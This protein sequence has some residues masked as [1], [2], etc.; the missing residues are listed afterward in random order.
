MVGFRPGECEVL[1]NGGNRRDSF[2]FIEIGRDLR[3]H[4][5]NFAPGIGQPSNTEDSHGGYTDVADPPSERE[6]TAG[7]PTV[8]LR[9]LSPL[10]LGSGDETSAD[11]SQKDSTYGF[12]PNL[13]APDRLG[14]ALEVSQDIR[15]HCR[16]RYPTLRNLLDAEAG[17]IDRLLAHNMVA[18]YDSDGLPATPS[19]APGGGGFSALWN[20]SALS[21][22]WNLVQTSIRL[23]K[24]LKIGRPVPRIPSP[25]KESPFNEY[26]RNVTNDSAEFQEMTRDMIDVI[27]IKRVTQAKEKASSANTA[28]GTRSAPSTS[29]SGGSTG[30][31]DRGINPT[32]SR[33][34]A[35][36][37]GNWN[38]RSGN[39]DGGA[40]GGEERRDNYRP[41]D[42]VDQNGY[43]QLHD[44]KFD[45]SNHH[46][47]R[48]C[49]IT[50]GQI[51]SRER[52]E[53]THQVMQGLGDEAD[54]GEPQDVKERLYCRHELLGSFPQRY[55]DV[56][57][58]ESKS[59][60]DPEPPLRCEN[61]QTLKPNLVA[62][63]GPYLELVPDTQT[64]PICEQDGCSLG[65]SKISSS[66]ISHPEEKV[67]TPISSKRPSPFSSHTAFS[68]HSPNDEPQNRSFKKSLNSKK[69]RPS[70]SPTF[71]LPAGQTDVELETTVQLDAQRP[72]T[73]LVSKLG[74]NPTLVTD[75]ADDV[76]R[77]GSHD[78][79]EAKD[80]R[81]ME[82]HLATDF[83]RGVRD[84]VNRW[85]ATVPIPNHLN[86]TSTA[87]SKA[88]RVDCQITMTDHPGPIS[89]QCF[90]AASESSS[91]QYSDDN[92]KSLL[93]VNFDV[94]GTGDEIRMLYLV[95][96]EMDRLIDLRASR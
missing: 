89:E 52:A 26:V 62:H 27:R 46:L 1:E 54:A 3:T 61:S 20:F 6:Q 48:E 53:D 15:D 79:K 81:E 86:S 42:G 95:K 17:D 78:I 70:E 85:L 33:R 77:T 59:T 39:D 32:R 87:G 93:A 11:S 35:G 21:T 22:M 31:D 72:Q 16:Q 74:T 2:R 56:L 63:R 65:Q 51:A 71:G 92:R 12:G 25:T 55:D 90:S 23:V 41:T 43:Q 5:K 18:S 96:E 4:K 73:A 49:Q 84:I 13:F 83:E 28:T 66:E 69:L 30:A 75:D 82:P 9:R 50:D 40:K 8:S 58:S 64:T 14:I 88:E 10:P 24:N 34:L 45:T 44:E 37:D 57:A 36:D 94:N 76:A 91:D 60:N 29:T 67:F 19:E 47:N 7:S 68:A 80:T 38:I